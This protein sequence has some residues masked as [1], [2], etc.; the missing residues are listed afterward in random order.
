MQEYIYEPLPDYQEQPLTEEEQ[1]LVDT[2]YRLLELFEEKEQNIIQEIKHNRKIWELKDGIQDGSQTGEKVM[3]LPTLIANV[4]SA[5]ADQVDNMPEVQLLP[6]TPEGRGAAQ[7]MA[8]VLHYILDRRGYKSM[9]RD[10]MVD[11]YVAKACILQTFWDPSLANGE[12]D[13][14]V[15]RWPIESFRWDPAFDNIQ[16]GRACF[17]LMWYPESWYREHYP[18]DSKYIRFGEDKSRYGNDYSESNENITM[19]MEYWYRRYDAEKKQY[20]IHSAKIAGHALL[21]SSEKEQPEGVYAHGMYPFDIYTY[22]K[23]QGT[24]VGRSM[25][26]DFI[27]PQ[28]RINRLSHYIDENARMS[29]RYKVLVS[30]QAKIDNE[31][32]T[33]WNQQIV[34]VQGRPGD[35][36]QQ[37]VVHQLNP[38]VDYHMQWLID[39]VIKRESGQN[40]SAR[41]EFGG[42]ITAASAIQSLQEAGTKVSRMRTVDFQQVFASMCTK[43]LW[44]AAQFYNKKRIFVITGDESREDQEIVVDRK[45]IYGKLPSNSALPPPPYAVQV[46]AQRGNP[47]K[48]DAENQMVMQMFQMYIQNGVRLPIYDVI[49]ALHIPGKD[50]LLRLA[51]DMDARNDEITMLT[52]Q[53]QQMQLQGQAMSA[54]NQALQQE[55]QKMSDIM[56]GQTENNV[57]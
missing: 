18:D 29:A 44:L 14:N 7:Q 1:D 55:L 20:A 50:R 10:V 46:V 32:L 2:A 31:Q 11:A 24:P 40:Q 57:L 22:R 52:Q 13:V 56:S 19:L 30:E 4:E 53:L 23:V 8:D 6:E 38:Q 37:L 9:H 17:K 47:Q 36:V 51:Q 35:Q 41:G 48:I 33:D 27:E 25:I 42:G 45:L 43:I 39:G 21:E 34:K 12:G 15:V 5:V 16:D 26:D 28:R 49:S 3:Q 54:Q